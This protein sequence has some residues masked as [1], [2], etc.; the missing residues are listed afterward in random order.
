MGAVVLTAMLAG[1][2][3]IP[4]AVGVWSGRRQVA[5]WRRQYSVLLAEA[6][7]KALVCDTCCEPW[8]CAVSNS[9]P[10]MRRVSGGYTGWPDHHPQHA[11]G[12]P[13]EPVPPTGPSGISGR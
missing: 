13:Y 5:E 7:P 11:D 6:Y 1:L 4:L 9:R 12:T 10:G 8:P 3:L 2:I